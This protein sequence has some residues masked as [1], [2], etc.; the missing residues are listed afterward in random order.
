MIKLKDNDFDE[1]DDE[2][3]DDQSV[4]IKREPTVKEFRKVLL[5]K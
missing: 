2:Q 3:Q 5:V 1:Y 4:N